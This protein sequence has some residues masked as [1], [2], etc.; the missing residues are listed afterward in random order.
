MELTDAW[1]AVF[2]AGGRIALIVVIAVVVN[3]L[4]RR[5][6]R[7]LGLRMRRAAED[8]RGRAP[9]VLVRGERAQRVDARANT[10]TSVASSVCSVV[11]G[12]IALLMVLSELKIDLGPLVAGAGVASIAIGFGAQSIVRDVL[13]GFFVVLEDQYGVGD[14]ID[15]GQA[16]GVV[17]HLSLRSTRL[18]DLSGTVW[19][20][21]NGA[22]VAVGNKSQN[23]ARAVIDVLV[24]HDADLRSARGVMR[25]VADE[26]AADAEW[27][28][29]LAGTIDEQGVQAV[30]PEGVTLRLVI[31]TEPA[32]QWAVERE[33][34]V[35]NK[36]AFDQAGIVMSSWSFPPPRGGT[37]AG[38]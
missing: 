19:H 36:E 13:A 25:A 32:S 27:S 11:I 14:I 8:V 21:P 24:S 30:G 22:I 37:G 35:R 2:L 18:R 33:L 28:K 7:R 4:S 20:I 38:A 3:V 10:L 23:W 31:D 12:V 26:L 16:S 34:R 1:R 15:A 17:E 29:R 6:I 9:N 5:G